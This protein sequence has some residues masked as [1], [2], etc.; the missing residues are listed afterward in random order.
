M[1]RTKAQ[2]GRI[3]V[4]T[5]HGTNDSAESLEG[6]KWYQRGSTF[7]ERLKQRLGSYGVD[8]EIIPYLWT[9]ANSALAR[10]RAAI[11][12]ARAVRTHAQE[13]DG[14][15]VIG[16]SHGGN[17]AD[18]AAR[19]LSWRRQGP[20][21]RYSGAITSVTTVG[22]P[23]FKS[24]LSRAESFGG[25][26]FLTIT[27][28]NMLLIVAAGLFAII[29]GAALFTSTREELGN[30][31]ALFAAL[32]V[33]VTISAVVMAFVAP[34]AFSGVRRIL[35][36][37]MRRMPDAEF[38]SIWHSNDEAI[39][40]LQKVET[41]KIEP[42]PR[43]SLLRGSQ[44]AAVLAGVR[45]VVWT[46]MGSLA[47]IIIGFV[48]YSI[49]SGLDLRPIPVTIWT[50]FPLFLLLISAMVAGIYAFNSPYALRSTLG[51]T[52]TILLLCIAAV[53]ADCMQ[54]SLSQNPSS[55]ALIFVGVA[56]FMFALA[57]A[58]VLFGIAYLLW[59]VIGGFGFEYGA[60]ERVNGWISGA[61]R[62]MAFGR[63]GDE[64][65][66][67]VS[68]VS[69][70]Y[71][72]RAEVLGGDLADRMQQAANEAA[73][74]LIDKY[75]W[76]LFTI[77]DETNGALSQLATDA[78]TWDSLIHTTYFDQP[79]VADLIGDYIA[80]QCGARLAPPPPVSAAA[81]A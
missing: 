9:G 47:A 18:T 8:A 51:W 11:Q 73:N 58:P 4:V 21:A 39:S 23:F 5:V 78:M 40:F 16:H 62:G 67:H 27:I 13:F 1:A 35:L 69:H 59:R 77:G 32:F 22:T 48:A 61:L 34:L 36:A 66:G 46:A 53:W 79:E 28:F 15:H 3:A 41:L 64:D 49:T 19:A 68:P 12:L 38:Y 50:A 75:R 70:S 37:R 63:D 74:K 6:A 76:A 55:E 44:T 29:G 72:A 2:A 14:V 7:S 20:L 80:E 60:R 81:T 33:A 10:E 54:R 30:E 52:I 24:A 65:I 17:V 42:F 71:G 31:G 43:G 25:W 26:A 56:A 45:A 57:G